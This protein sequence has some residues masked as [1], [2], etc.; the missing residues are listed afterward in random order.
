MRTIQVN[1]VKTL[2]QFKKWCDKEHT[3]CYSDSDPFEK[4][5][6]L[7]LSWTREIVNRLCQTEEKVA[8]PV[9]PVF[10]VGQIV[11]RTSDG[12]RCLI[13]QDCCNNTY[14]VQLNDGSQFSEG[15]ILQRHPNVTHGELAKMSRGYC[16]ITEKQGKEMGYHW[17]KNPSGVLQLNEG[18]NSLPLFALHGGWAKNSECVTDCGKT[19]KVA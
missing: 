18:G 5:Y 8:P 13:H 9:E 2:A 3:P 14:L 10:K 16:F 7:C 15:V 19:H 12:L 1:E 11:R 6:N 17:A 4:G